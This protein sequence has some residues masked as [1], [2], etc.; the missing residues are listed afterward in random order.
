MNGSS[1]KQCVSFVCVSIIYQKP[2]KMSIDFLEKIHFFYII[3]FKHF[4]SS[5]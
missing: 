5:V 1:E 2:Q 3:Y 4:T